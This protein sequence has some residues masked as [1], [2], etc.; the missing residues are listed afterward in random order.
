M[1]LIGTLPN[2]KSV[3]RVL[4]TEYKGGVNPIV[5]SSKKPRIYVQKVSGKRRNGTLITEHV[6]VA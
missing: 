2:L 5:E 1:T 6:T 4:H 3:K